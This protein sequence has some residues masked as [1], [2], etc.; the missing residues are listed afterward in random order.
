[1]VAP[2]AAREVPVGGGT[3]LF[4]DGRWVERD[5]GRTWERGTLVRLIIEDGDLVLQL[6]VDPRDGWD[7]GRLAA[8]A[9][10]LR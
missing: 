6:A 9:A 1:P 7:A 4:I 2:G 3:G 5:G 8:V 10:T